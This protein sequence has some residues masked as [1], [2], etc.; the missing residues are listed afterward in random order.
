[1]IFFHSDKSTTLDQAL[2]R[3]EFIGLP[4]I[5]MEQ[6]HGDTIS[7]ATESKSRTFP[8]TDAL[9]TTLPNV[10]L[11]IRTADCVTILLHHDSGVIGAIHAGRRG[12]DQKIFQKFLQKLQNE[13]DVQDNLDIWIGPHICTNCYQVD[14]QTDSHYDLKSENLTQLYSFFSPDQINL[15]ISPDCTVCNNDRYFSY[16]KEGTTERN[17]SL[18][19][20]MT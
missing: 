6:V 19:T 5:Q 10:V 16:R 8:K 1:M 9:I 14:R 17:F 11:A 18:I 2:A 20:R 15:T 13:F 7:V 3:P 4:F 12:T